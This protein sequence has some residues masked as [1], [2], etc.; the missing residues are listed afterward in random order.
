M[1]N[2]VTHYFV[3][4]ID[5]M[6]KSRDL[7]KDWEDA[8]KTLEVEQYETSKYILHNKYA[9]VE[10]VGPRKEL[11]TKFGTLLERLEEYGKDIRDNK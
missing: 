8:E 4:D 11:E 2:Y 6:D 3:A 1:T 5:L 9:V 10:V 7:D